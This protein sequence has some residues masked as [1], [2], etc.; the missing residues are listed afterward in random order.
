MQCAS[1]GSTE[2][3][4]PGLHYTHTTKGDYRDSAQLQT[5]SDLKLVVES[6]HDI[7][8]NSSGLRHPSLQHQP[9]T[10]ER[11]YAK[12]KRYDTRFLVDDS[13][14]MAGR[15]WN[16]VKKVMAEIASIAVKYDSDGVDVDFFNSYV[17]DKKRCN[18][19]SIDDVMSLF[20]GLFPEGETPTADKLDE[21]LNEFCHE[22]NRNRNMKGL[23][24]IVLTD[25]EPSAGQDVEAVLVKYAKKLQESQAPLLKVGVQFVQVGVDE[26]AS[27]FLQKLDDDIQAMHG[28][29]RDVRDSYFSLQSLTLMM[30]RWLTR[31]HG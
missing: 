23:N 6:I 3:L 19:K 27:R 2:S 9:S 5:H 15:K 12:L 4:P 11:V 20:A 31:S 21:V 8:V 25:G 10:S 13:D 28:L 30:H 1:F 14:S 17:E 26:G 16:R 29:D 7:L 18:L 24:L 22:F